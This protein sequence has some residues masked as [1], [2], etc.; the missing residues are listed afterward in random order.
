MKPLYRPL[1]QCILCRSAAL[2]V[3]VPLAP[4][5]IATPTFAV[6]EHLRGSQDAFAAA[7][8]YLVLC[9]EC[10]HLQ[11][12]HVIDP[13]FSYSNYVYR[14]ASS[15]GLVDHFRGLADRVRE[16]LAPPAGALVVEIGS[17]DGSLL[18]FFQDRGHKVLGVDP[19]EKIAAQAT[20]AGIPTWARF[21]DA[22]VAAEIVAKAGPATIAI[23]NNVIANVEDVGVFARGLDG[24]LT[25]DDVFVFET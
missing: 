12:S 13:A 16:R 8:L 5:P 7:P 3:V 22:G 11:T 25:N 10:G 20:A 19:A 21:F 14:T 4:I 23:A 24:L 17:N 2:E 6:P 18:R 9:Q 15:L 1:A